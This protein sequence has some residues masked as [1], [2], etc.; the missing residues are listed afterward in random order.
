MVRSEN[1]EVVPHQGLKCPRCGS[2]NLHHAEVTVFDR[3]EDDDNV[4]KTQV[5]GGKAT[6]SVAPSA[7]DNPSA[8]RGGVTIDFVCEQCEGA[9]QL[10][11]A[12]HKGSTLVEWR[13]ESD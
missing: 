13:V 9:L 12:Q 3:G 2:F 11:M 6:T 10:T 7:P 4:V 8:R 5:V 1:V